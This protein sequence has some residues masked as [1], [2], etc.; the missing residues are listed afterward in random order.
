MS[1]FRDLIIGSFCIGLC[2]LLIATNDA[3]I[4]F[5]KM[6]ESQL[7][8]GRFIIEFILAVLWWIF[9]KPQQSQNWYGDPPYITHIWLRAVFY[10][11]SFALAWYSYIRLPIGDATCIWCQSPILIS[12]IAWIFL[13]ERLP[14]TT[15]FIIILSIIGIAFIVQPTFLISIYIEYIEPLIDKNETDWGEIEPLNIEGV[16]AMILAV[17]T[18]SISTVLV[19]TAKEVHFIQLQIVSAGQTAFALVPLLL[20][21]NRVTLHNSYIGTMMEWQWDLNSILILVALGIFGFGGLS[22]YVIGFQYA[23]A[24]KV[25]WLEYITI[26]FSFLYQI[27]LF[28]DIPNILEVIG[29]SFVVTACCF[30]L[31]EEWYYY[32]IKRNEETLYDRFEDES[33]ESI[34]SVEAVVL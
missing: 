12:I 25:A 5:S 3:I 6:K 24:T 33:V 34:E 19:R 16:I 22:L 1:S 28:N 20:W 32:H 14:K 15:P 7:L 27:F 2:Q 13:G 18:W 4:K 23:A 11:L 26:V 17:I 10:C 21:I 31:L 30:S 8:F 29:L 9:N